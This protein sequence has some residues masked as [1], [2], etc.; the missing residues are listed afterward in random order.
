MDQLGSRLARE[1]VE[2]DF[3]VE[4]HKTD[5]CCTGSLRLILEERPATG[6][7]QTPIYSNVAFQLLGMACE[8][9][10]GE[11]FPDLFAKGIA[12]PLGLHRTSWLPPK[13]DSNSVLF[14]IDGTDTYETDLGV[15]D[16]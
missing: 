11:A 14:D 16:P 7:W 15:L 3:C 4:E 5:I 8:N 2:Q 1:K 10:T 9:I 6:V 12:A 13:N